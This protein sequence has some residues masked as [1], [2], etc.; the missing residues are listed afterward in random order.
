MNLVIRILVVCMLMAP[1]NSD[2]YMKRHLTSLPVYSV[3]IYTQF[4]SQS[5]E[6]KLLKSISQVEY[7][8][9]ITQEAASTGILLTVP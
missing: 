8:M 1:Q 9:A 4:H 3:F 2:N 7:P 5:A 6:P